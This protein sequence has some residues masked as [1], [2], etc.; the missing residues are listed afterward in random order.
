MT[1]PPFLWHVTGY[2]VPTRRCKHRVLLEAGDF[3]LVQQ[4]CKAI[5]D[6]SAAWPAGAEPRVKQVHRTLVDAGYW[7]SAPPPLPPRPPRRPPGPV[8]LPV[9]EEQRR[10]LLGI[11]SG[12]YEPDARL[13]GIA[14]PCSVADVNQAFRRRAR[15]VHPDA[16]GLAADFVA[17]AAARDRL[18]G[19]AR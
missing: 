18:L 16:G 8:P 13:L 7:H 14:L 4:G 11:F 10:A 2:P 9:T 15:G 5:P 1:A 17:L 3:L 19:V 6:P 12:A